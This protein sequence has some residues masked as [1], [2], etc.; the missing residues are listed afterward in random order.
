MLYINL[1]TFFWLKV[2]LWNTQ[3]WIF[4][5]FICCKIESVLLGPYCC[6]ILDFFCVLTQQYSLDPPRTQE[7]QTLSNNQ[8]VSEPGCKQNLK[9]ETKQNGLKSEYLPNIARSGA[10]LWLTC[11]NA[12][13][14]LLGWKNGWFE[15]IVYYIGRQSRSK[16]VKRKRRK[17]HLKSWQLFEIMKNVWT[18]EKNWMRN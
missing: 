6:I 13:H 11:F 7:E 3:K 9:N 18:P 4:F 8:I 12:L 10:L 16:K 2:L 5:S 14:T 1:E 15:Q 17:K